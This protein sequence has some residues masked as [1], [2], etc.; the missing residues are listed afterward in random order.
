MRS[1]RLW[2]DSGMYA[3]IEWRTEKEKSQMAERKEN[4]GM[5]NISKR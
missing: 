5:N 4:G 2:I 3:C 1:E